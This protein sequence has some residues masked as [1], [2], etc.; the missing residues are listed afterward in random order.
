M[1]T[2][3]KQF[4]SLLLLTSFIMIVLF[5]FM[6]MAHGADGDMLGDCPFAIP[7]GATLC[8]QD[9]L[10]MVSYHISALRAFL[11]VPVSFMLILLAS[12]AWV[13][14]LALIASLNPPNS[15]QPLSSRNLSGY[16][17]G[18]LPL[19]RKLSRW[20]S[21]LEHSPATQ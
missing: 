5:G 12:L 15:N 20:L 16:L 1:P 8:P 10:S 17:L 3:Y 21:L 18:V 6:T 19:R 11:G 4:F 7:S 9:S 13:M 2:L 14:C